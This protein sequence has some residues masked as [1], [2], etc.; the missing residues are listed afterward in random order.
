MKQKVEIT[1]RI[2]TVS[3]STSAPLPSPE[4]V[5]NLVAA[6]LSLIATILGLIA[7]L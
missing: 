1:I 6:I 7:V 3:D 5:I 2:E 4:S